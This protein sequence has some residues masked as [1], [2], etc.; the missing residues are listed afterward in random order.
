MADT[1]DPTEQLNL[2][3]EKY[4]RKCEKYRQSLQTAQEAF[5]RQRAKLDEAKDRQRRELNSTLTNSTL[6]EGYLK[7]AEKQTAGVLEKLGKVRAQN[8]G[9]R[10]KINK[11]RLSNNRTIEVI[12]HHAAAVKE[13]EEKKQ[14]QRDLAKHFND[15]RVAVEAETQT[16]A[17]RE[18]ES[19]HEF[20]V[21]LDVA[22]QVHRQAAAEEGRRLSEMRKQRKQ[23]L[24]ESGSGG[25][26]AGT[27]GGA[28]GSATAHKKLLKRG[29]SVRARFCLCACR[30][31]CVP[32]CLCACLPVC[33]PVF[34]PA[35]LPVFVPVFVPVCVPA[36]LHACVPT[37]AGRPSSCLSLRF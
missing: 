30:C 11:L 6:F 32:V 37:F 9:L 18:K 28:A 8:E 29:S 4:T 35:C 12:G 17:Q 23:A 1:A 25:V 19:Q 13:S 15:E 10:S 3:A 24:R 14:L 21:S 20:T 33:L 7:R 26:G 36:C 22:R 5:E 31:A 2:R 27:G 16:L 34:V